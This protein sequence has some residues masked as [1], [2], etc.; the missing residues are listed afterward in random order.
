MPLLTGS[1]LALYFGEVEIFSKIDLE[2]A[3]KAHIGMVGPNGQGKTSLLRMLMGEIPPNSGSVSRSRGLTIGYV[4][5]HAAHMTVGTLREE[6]MS[7]F[8]AILELETDVADAGMAIERAATPEE[9]KL[10][11]RRYSAL[12]QEYEAVGGFDY[13]NRMERVVTGVGLSLESLDTPV[14]AASGGQKTRAALAK[15]LL[16]EPALLILDEPTNYLDFKGLA[17]LET[18]LNRFPYAFIVVSHDRYFLDRVADQI[19]DMDGGGLKAYRGNYTKFRQVKEE[20]RARQQLEFERQQ[21]VIAREQAFIDRY[22]A[23]V[24]ARQAMGREKRLDRLERLDAVDTADTVKIRANEASRTSLTVLTTHDLAVGYVD[25]GRTVQLL[26]VPETKLERGSRTAIVGPNGLGKTTLLN[27]IIGKTPPVRGSINFGQKVK[28]GFQ[29]QGSDDI[30]AHLS[31]LDALLDAKNIN[32]GEARG[33]LAR[34]L[35]KGDDVFK[36][37]SSLSGG[38]RTRLAL[39]RLLIT[40]PNVLVLDEPTT[41]LD[42]PSR[43]ALEDALLDYAGALL[44]VSHDRHLIGLLAQNLWLVENGALRVFKG[45]FEEWLKSL[46]EP[47]ARA[48]AAQ[49]KKAAQPQKG[50]AKGGKAAAPKGPDHEKVIAD[51]EALVVKLEASLQ[52]AAEKNDRAKVAD[53]AEAHAKAQADLE[54]AWAAWGGLSS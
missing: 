39:A 16:L 3:E 50:A 51:L 45:T 19:W 32:I 43:E 28:I 34:F 15:A 8:S 36:L 2:V 48:Q 30:P 17:W 44:F 40:E 26:S 6:V 18:F 38:E 24:K 31:V 27:T 20:Q 53:L 37:V 29:K 11:D 13:Q 4:S 23:G 46:E 10:A 9:R 35:F 22:R 12:L 1:Q 47:A 7:A 14:T 25:G 21:E 52:K 5:Q 54:L 42:I 33:Y 49:P 41:H